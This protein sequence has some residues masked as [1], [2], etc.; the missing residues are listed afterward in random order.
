MLTDPF[1][2]RTDLETEIENIVHRRSKIFRG[3][4]SDVHQRLQDGIVIGIRQTMCDGLKTKENVR[5]VRAL[6]SRRPT[7]IRHGRQSR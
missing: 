2:G 3:V 6:L 1:D 5:G 7:A 4:F